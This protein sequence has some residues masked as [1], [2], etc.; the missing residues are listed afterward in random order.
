MTSRLSEGVGSE[1]VS[2]RRAE[3]SRASAHRQGFFGDERPR[4]LFCWPNQFVSAE[5]VHALPAVSAPLG[6]ASMAAYLRDNRWRGEMAVYDARLSAK[7]HT[8]SDG[9]TLFGDTD[10]EM[11]EHIRSFRPHVI[12]ISNMFTVQ[13]EQALHMADIAKKVVPNAVI[14]MGGPHVSSYPLE[15]ASHASVDFAVMGEGEERLYEIL[16]CLDE[17]REVCIQ[18]VISGPDDMG[19]LR[20]S[21]KVPIGFIEPLDKLRIPAYDMLDMERYFELQ[22][23]GYSPRP[24]S[25]RR[26]MT[27]MTSRGCPHQCVFCS[28]QATMGYKWRHNSPEYVEK[29]L[30][31]LIDAYGVDFVHFEDD[32]FTHDPDRFDEIL[33]TLLS[34]EPRLGW[35]TTNGV[36]GDTWDHKRVGRTK[37]AGCIGLTV[38]IESGV[39]EVLD[40]IVKKTARPV[41]GRKPDGGLQGPPSSVERLLHYRLSRREGQRHSGDD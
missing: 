23:S 13:I 16:C 12:A 33:D 11:S 26:S 24:E 14:V 17:G 4:L 31:H 38:A 20:K 7:F 3:G 6:I 32:N 21:K 5:G 34:F 18:G 30:R 36:R 1:N 37:D 29:H 8:Q 22:S 10:D 39:Q 35:D 2:A 28:I 41:E 9:L 40:K 27:V 19:L 25:G 15:I